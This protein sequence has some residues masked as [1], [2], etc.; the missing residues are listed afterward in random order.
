VAG[1]FMLADIGTKPLASVRFEFLKKLMGMDSL[2]VK[3][4]E[5]IEVEEKVKEKE[6]IEVEEKERRRKA[7]VKSRT[8]VKPTKTAIVWPKLLRYFV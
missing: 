8:A 4:E 7:K 2:S 5:K 1:E 6:K 3:S